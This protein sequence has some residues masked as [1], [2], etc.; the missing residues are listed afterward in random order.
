MLRERHL[1]FFAERVD[2]GWCLGSKCLPGVPPA[3][4]WK[5]CSL[6][7]HQISSEVQEG[8]LWLDEIEFI[9]VPE[10]LQAHVDW[11]CAN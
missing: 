7:S 3:G 11:A 8:F 9:P 4:N 2:A 5:Q 6:A 10:V 1:G